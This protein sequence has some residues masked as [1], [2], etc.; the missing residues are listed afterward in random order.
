MAEDSSVPQEPTREEI[1]ALEGPALIEFGATWCGHCQ[2]LAPKLAEELAKRPGI[3]HLKI[4]DGPG[5]RLGRSFRVK[6]WPT[7]V[8][9]R[10]GQVVKQVSRP[11]LREV[12]EGLESIAES[13]SS[14]EY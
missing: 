3:P 1:D 13:A 5:R 6:L 4:E 9:M 7:L 2:A 14:G 12:R 11:E 8:F 10:D